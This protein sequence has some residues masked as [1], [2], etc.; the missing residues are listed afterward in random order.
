MPIEIR[1]LT[2]NIGAEI[3]GV[4]LESETDLETIRL[5]FV[6]HSVI[7]IRGLDLAPEDHLKF[8][9]SW[10]EINV[11]RFFKPVD[12]Y[13]E[14]ATVL[15]EADQKSA[16]GETWHTDHSYD[17][18]PAMCSMLYAREVPDVG[19]DTCFASQYAAYDAL[20]D[21]MKTTLENLKAWHS[22]RHAFGVAQTDEEAHQ[23]G[24]LGNENAATQDALHPVVLTHPLSGKKCL[25]VNADFTTRFHGW[26]MEE[27]QPLL[28][29]LYTHCSRADFT[30]RLRWE[31][32]TL[33]IWDNRA[34]QHMAMNDYPGKRRL[35]HRITIEGVPLS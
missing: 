26:T 24:R 10:G 18:A 5:A 2:P 13:P 22:S 31:K 25:Y 8:A 34:T 28:N 21:G 33:A 7:A 27:S 9:R 19:G 6:E 12:G 20:S 29:Q 23:D 16:I 11:N 32:G 30:C 14:I 17:T 3:F 4:D 1:P 15:K 35:M